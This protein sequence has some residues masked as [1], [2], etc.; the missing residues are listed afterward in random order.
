MSAPRDRRTKLSKLLQ[1]GFS[2]MAYV[3]C[4]SGGLTRSVAQAPTG[5]GGESSVPVVTSY[6]VPEAPAFT[7]L[8]LNPSKVTRPISP[9]DLGV[10]V[11]QA[12]D[13][14][15]RVQQGFALSLTPWYYLPGFTIPLDQYQRSWPAYVAAT[16]SCR[17]GP[18]ALRATA[19]PPTWPWHYASRSS[20]VAI[21]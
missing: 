17:S 8:G 19:L 13:S 5:S 14:S 7:F 18:R 11:L 6:A 9:R 21:Q 16:P 20:T 3:S 12:V 2:V 1:R 4:L 10:A 15:G